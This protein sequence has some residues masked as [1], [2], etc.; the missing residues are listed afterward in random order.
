MQRTYLN[1]TAKGTDFY[2]P[3]CARDD[4]RLYALSHKVSHKVYISILHMGLKCE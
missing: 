3:L 2:G 1:Q 4:I